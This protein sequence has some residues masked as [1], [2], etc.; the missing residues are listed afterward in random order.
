MDLPVDQYT[1]PTVEAILN[2]RVACSK[3]LDD[4]L[5]LDVV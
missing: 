4:I 1:A 3:M 5:V 2:E